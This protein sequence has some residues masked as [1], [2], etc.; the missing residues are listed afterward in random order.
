MGVIPVTFKF[1]Q[2]TQHIANL[3]LI[4]SPEIKYKGNGTFGK[5]TE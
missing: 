4:P 5:S 1:M 3:I 2:Q